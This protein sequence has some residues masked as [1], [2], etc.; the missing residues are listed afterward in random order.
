[1]ESNF[2]I[3]MCIRGKSAISGTVLGKILS[4]LMTG[5]TSWAMLLGKQGTVLILICFYFK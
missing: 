4:T 2:I 5:F 1:M 3:Q